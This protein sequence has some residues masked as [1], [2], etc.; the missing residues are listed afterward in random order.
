MSAF[1]YWIQDLFENWI[2]YYT[3]DQFRRDFGIFS[4]SWWTANTLN[5]IFMIIGFA[6]MVYWMGQLKIF[7]DND[8]EDKSISSHSYI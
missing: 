7:S 3:M 1:F 2:F 5:W 4:G 8:E 6:A